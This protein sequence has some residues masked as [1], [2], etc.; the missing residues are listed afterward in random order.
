MHLSRTRANALIRTNAFSKGSYIQISAPKSQEPAFSGYGPPFNSSAAR[1]CEVGGSAR[2]H[3]TSQP[4]L[5]LRLSPRQ[6]EQ[7]HSP[8]SMRVS[9]TGGQGGMD[10]G[11]TPSRPSY[12]SL[13]AQRAQLGFCAPAR[14]KVRT[15]AATTLGSNPGNL[16]RGAV[17]ASSQVWETVRA[18]PVQGSGNSPYSR[19]HPVF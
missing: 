12:T 15:W 18:G 14:D 1:T 16:R 11:P 17:N 2:W 3:H 6:E 9:E 5:V 19:L 8:D 4:F 7:G 10:R 13:S